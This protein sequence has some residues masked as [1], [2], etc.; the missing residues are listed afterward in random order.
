MSKKELKFTV[1][2]ALLGELGEKLVESVHIA[3]AEL[4]KNS[5]DA[6]STR[7]EISFDENDKGNPRIII[8][9]NGTGMSFESVQNYWMR[10]ATTNK[11]TRNQSLVF[12]RPLTGAKG[13]GRFSCR[14]LGDKLTLITRGTKNNDLQ[15]RQ[16]DIQETTIIF[17]WIEEFTEGR[18]VTSIL[19]QGEQK[20]LDGA[21]TGTTLIIEDIKDE[22]QKRGFNWLKRQLS[23]LAAN[24]GTKRRDGFKIDPGFN[25]FL[26]A[27]DLEGDVIDLRDSLKKAGWG[28]L[29]AHINSKFQ[30]VCTLDA[31]GLGRKTIIS[32]EKFLGLKDINLELGILIEQRPFI[33]DLSILSK[34]TTKEIKRDWGGVQV[35]YKGF[36][37][38]PY[39]DDDWLEIDKDRGKRL[40][41]P[42]YEE[43]FKFAQSL[44]GINPQRVM[45]T[46]LEMNAFLGG[47]NIG[48]Q[49][50]GFEMKMNREGF[51]DSPEFDQLKRFIRFAIDW[52]MI[53]REDQISQQA[54]Q[55]VTTAR[56]ELENTIEQK[57]SPKKVV[58]AAVSH[59]ETQISNIT[60]SLKPE[61]RKEVKESFKKATEVIRRQNESYQIQLSK[62]RLVASTSTLLYIFSHEVRS[63]LGLLRQSSSSLVEIADRT[64]EEELR[65]IAEEFH[66]LNSRLID[67]L[68]L[69]SL[70]SAS[71]SGKESTSL[72][73]KD[74]IKQVVEV[75]DLIVTKYDIDID[76]TD[77]PPNIHVELREAELFSIFLNVISNSIKAVIAGI[78]P[79]KIRI[80]AYMESGKSII[81]IKDNGIGLSREK[82]DDV[83]IP[84]VFDPE[85]ILYESLDKRL[86]EN[87]K[88][89]IGSGTGLGL[90][91]VGEIVRVNGGEINFID[92]TEDWSTILRICLK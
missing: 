57:I 60:R 86:S 69:T 29:K 41:K 22:W 85:G 47:V 4:V 26:Y 35:Y 72:P 76:Y 45:L 33:R 70:V 39:G 51:I 36:R 27:P 13:I 37:V 32:K 17:P 84:F 66:D 34:Q 48:E 62:L 7:V 6:D 56:E 30:A 10:I 50:E 8:S 92:E 52:S 79:K 61:Q 83:F 88:D 24:Q 3:L 78:F 15:G 21:E 82:F 81:E 89:V 53:T 65:V 58:E 71:S 91:I 9:D 19:V 1:D 77:V 38:F 31:M 12:G 74:R 90:S 23:V 5:Y 28:T 59:I 16:K 44:R 49:S 87:D 42:K 40:A 20:I 73:I 18:D 11:R 25:V 43:L 55:K 75:F 2:S 14:R 54:F 68:Q 67:L 64:K 80:E 63:L 46:L